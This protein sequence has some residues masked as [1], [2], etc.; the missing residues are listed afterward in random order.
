MKRKTGSYLELGSLCVLQRVKCTCW[1]SSC[2]QCLLTQPSW[3]WG[4]L[5]LSWGLTSGSM[6]DQRSAEFPVLCLQVAAFSSRPR[7]QKRLWKSREE[8]LAYPKEVQLKVRCTSNQLTLSHFSSVPSQN[9]FFWGR[10]LSKLLR[11]TCS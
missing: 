9:L 2:S 8:D 7:D 1:V 5:G 3:L 10:A 11:I 6:R 4:S